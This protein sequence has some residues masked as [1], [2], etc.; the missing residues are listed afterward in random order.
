MSQF[1]F[2]ASTVNPEWGA[3]GFFPV[4]DDK[5]HLVV[6]T[7]VGEMAPASTGAGSFLPL[8]LKIIEGT[9][10]GSEGVLRLNLQHEKQGAVAAAFAQLSALVHVCGKYP[11]INHPSELANIPFRVVS[12][13]Q[14]ASKPDGYTQ[15][16][17]NGIRDAQGNKPG[18]PGS[19]PQSAGNQAP[20]NPNQAPQNPQGGGQPQQ[21]QGGT[22]GGWGPQGGAG[23]PNAGQ[24]PQGGQNWGPQGNQG[25]QGNQN[26]QGG[27][28]QNWG[29]QGG[30]QPQGDPNAAPNWGNNQGGNPAQG[31]GG[32]GG[33]NWGNQGGGNQG[34][35]S[36]GAPQ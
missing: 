33:P 18:K 10:S 22:G 9:L 34:G 6:I 35:P 16:A 23:D 20:Q 24:T 13:L 12:V 17:N 25:G 30:G 14:D 36:W 32:Q 21:G 27:G 4:S 26:P 11:R 7:S 28:N 1:M 2:D 19:G 5:G 8:N 15:L 31:Q 3:S 29:P